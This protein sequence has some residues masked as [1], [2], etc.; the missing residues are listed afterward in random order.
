[1]TPSLAISVLPSLRGR[2]I[3][4]KLL[5]ELLSH[6]PSDRIGLSVQNSNPAKRLY[7]RI[8]FLTMRESVDESVMVWTRTVA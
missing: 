8:G 6:A 2:G 7:E 3:G 4:T 1:M 5:T